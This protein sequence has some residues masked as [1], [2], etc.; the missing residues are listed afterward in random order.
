MGWGENI[1]N[2]HILSFLQHSHLSTLPN[3]FNNVQDIDQKNS[4]LKLEHFGV[5]YDQNCVR[6]IEK[7]INQ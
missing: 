1:C 5:E 2:G 7:S 3:S 4:D 6:H